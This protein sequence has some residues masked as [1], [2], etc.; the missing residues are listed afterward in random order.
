ANLAQ[1]TNLQIN[2]GEY[3]N[4][5]ATLNTLAGSGGAQYADFC[6]LMPIIIKYKQDTIHR[7]FGILKD[8]N[9]LV[10]VERISKDT[11]MPGSGAAK[12]VLALIFNKQ[13]PAYIYPVGNNNGGGN[14]PGKKK[15]ET[16]NNSKHSS[17]N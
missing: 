8:S 1:I 4:A 11:T 14:K 15:T 13:F 2:A 10:T 7:Y 12:A 6:A 9:S 3:N 16:S 17:G 5:S